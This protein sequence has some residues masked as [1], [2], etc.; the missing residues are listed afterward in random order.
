MPPPAPGRTRHWTARVKE[1][2]ITDAA[3]ASEIQ[4]AVERAVEELGVVGAAAAVVHRGEEVF[5]GGFGVREQAGLA[6]DAD[7]LFAIG[8]DHQKLHHPGDCPAGRER[9][10]GLGHPYPALSARLRAP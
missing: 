8:S 7:T 4:D 3:N 5:I 9:C 2:A 10:A 6:V 1:V